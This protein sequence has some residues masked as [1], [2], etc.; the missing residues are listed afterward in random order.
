MI[1]SRSSKKS[2]PS[3]SLVGK[4]VGLVVQCVNIGHNN[5]AV[6]DTLTHKEMPPRDVFGLLMTV[7]S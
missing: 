1:R 7:S 3:N 4:E 2:F 6:L 5:L